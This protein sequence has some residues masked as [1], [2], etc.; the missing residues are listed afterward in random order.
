MGINVYLAKFASELANIV[1]LRT[2][3]TNVNVTDCDGQSLLIH[4]VRRDHC[5]LIE[6][7]I[8]MGADVSLCDKEGKLASHWAAQC[9]SVKALA[10]LAR[11][12]CNID[13]QDNSGWT[14]MHHAVSR[15]ESPTLQANS[16]VEIINALVQY[17]A[18]VDPNDYRGQTPLHYATK[19]N[20]LNVLSALLWNKADI[21][22]RDEKGM[23]PLHHAVRRYSFD[24][25]KALLRNHADTESR[26]E[27]GMTP[28]HYSAWQIQEPPNC[29]LDVLMEGGAY[30]NARDQ[31]ERTPLHYALRVPSFRNAEILLS[32]KA[33]IH[34][35]DKEGLTPLGYALWL[36]SSKQF[37]IAQVIELLQRYGA[38]ISAV[39]PSGETLLHWSLRHGLHECVAQLV[40][41]GADISRPDSNRY[42]PIW[43]AVLT[44]Q[45]DVKSI[46]L[47][48]NHGASMQ[49][50]DQ[51]GC[52]L[53][54][55]AVERAKFS[56]V[57]V[58][59]RNGASPNAKNKHG[60][61][62]FDFAMS[63]GLVEIGQFLFPYIDGSLEILVE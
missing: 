50:S 55:R 34:A 39:N 31:D 56:V 33:D 6:H 44:S 16:A 45:P 51:E 32:S 22:S 35:A 59:V 21:E 54:H 1:F 13:A 48:I 28:L 46:Q 4:A 19:L 24:A 62:S 12:R 52:T 49:E 5:V 14:P 36:H 57:K 11:S 37:I 63:L 2:T 9:G 27:R 38:D 3:E 58:L 26:E 43:R 23:T 29:T 41:C 30:V 10:I 40:N 60:Q 17:G 61:S 8:E 20:W 42:S 25:L 18:N 7:L 53:L 47:L 15:R